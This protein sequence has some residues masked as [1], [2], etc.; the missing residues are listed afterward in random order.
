[1]Y[2]ISNTFDEHLCQIIVHWS[3]IEVPCSETMRMMLI[4]L[5]TLYSSPLSVLDMLELLLSSP[6]SM[7][8]YP[9]TASRKFISELISLMVKRQPISFIYIG[10]HL[11]LSILK[12][13]NDLVSSLH[14]VEGNSVRVPWWIMYWVTFYDFLPCRECGMKEW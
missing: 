5:L 1:M 9:A 11:L 12:A 4:L 7:Q 3:L 14:K 10:F 13:L 6:V 2:F 8:E